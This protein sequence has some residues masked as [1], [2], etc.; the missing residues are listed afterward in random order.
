[1]KIHL[2]GSD[3]EFFIRDL[4]TNKIVSSTRMIPGTKEEPISL[5][6]ILGKGFSIQKDNVLVEACVPPVKT[7]G[8]MHENIIK[9]KNYV[10]NSLFKGAYE[11]VTLGSHTMD[12]SELTDPSTLEFGCSISL[13]AWNEEENPKPVCE[14]N[15]RFRSAGGHIHISYDNSNIFTNFE[16]IKW[17]DLY[18][19]VPSLL[20][21]K[22]VE[23][24]KLYGK[25][26][27]MRHTDFGCEYR[28]LSN[29]WVFDSVITDFLFRQLHLAVSKADQ[30]FLSP[31]EGL[32]IQ[33]CINTNN[34]E[35]AKEICAK[36]KINV[37]L[38]STSVSN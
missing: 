23:R 35:M 17:C 15:S 22:D 31:E 29:F 27:E 18:L 36:Y 33:T 9:F 30:E 24:R 28:T 34:V 1:M 2:I 4:A 7:A 3:P 13:N 16:V 8:E 10:N 32:H 20:L 19:G 38:L 37:D 5:E 11:L 21:D 12:A 25:A 14:E 26:G 6:E